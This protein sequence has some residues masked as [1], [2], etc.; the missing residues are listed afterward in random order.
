MSDGRFLPRR[1]GVTGWALVAAWL[2]LLVLVVVS[3]TSAREYLQIHEARTPALAGLPYSEAARLAGEAGLELRSYGVEARGTAPDTVTE[4]SPPA[5]SVV[6]RGRTISVGVNVPVEADRMPS[7]VGNSETDALAT[8]REL[9]LPSPDVNYAFSERPAGRIVEQAPSAGSEVSRDDPVRLIVSRGRGPEQVELPDLVGLDVEAAR[10]QLTVLGVRRIET[11]AVGVSM[12]RSGVVTQQRPA[13][14]SVVGTGEPVTL[15]YALDASRVAYIPDVVG[16]EPWRARDAL[17][18]AG[19]ATGPVEVVQRDDAPEGVVE[20]RPSGLTAAGAP[21]VLV[22]NAA[23]GTVVDLAPEEGIGSGGGSGP[24]ADERP[25]RA[26]DEDDPEAAGPGGRTV[27][28]RF[29]PAELG[30]RSLLE[31]DYDLRVVVN[32]ARGE[33]TEI[34]EQV[35]AG[36]AV[37]SSV[38]VY[39]DEPL[40]QTYVNGVFFQAWRP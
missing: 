35:E 9:S 16:M 14:G 26:G 18:S 4:Q 12:L 20:T 22:V 11:V 30:V 37:R 24:S 34:D 32:D 33:R 13:P 10:T 15:G 19:L 31:S 6:R 25:F 5:G 27:P 40:L 28:F 21:V 29:D 23:P 36:E 1:L 3:A 2:A 39:G 17:R 8:L 38:T 7:L